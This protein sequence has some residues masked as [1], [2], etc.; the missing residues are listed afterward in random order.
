[1]KTSKERKVETRKSQENE[2]FARKW[3]RDSSGGPSSWFRVRIDLRK[4]MHSPWDCFARVSEGFGSLLEGAR[5]SAIERVEIGKFF[6]M[7]N[8]RY[9]RKP[10]DDG[11]KIL[12]HV[13]DHLWLLQISNL[14]QE[15][16]RKSFVNRNGSI[17]PEMG[18]K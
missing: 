11:V 10:V 4:I 14:P 6:E 3:K 2:I 12:R 8:G 13:S 5:G 17:A 16:D 7:I 15:R 9:Y 18:I 1:M